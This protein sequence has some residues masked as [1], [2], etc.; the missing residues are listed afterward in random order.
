VSSGDVAIVKQL[1]VLQSIA[2]CAIS[3]HL[4]PE[5]NNP[6]QDCSEQS[7]S[8]ATAEN[9]ESIKIQKYFIF[10]VV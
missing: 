8:A 7:G 1:Y 6:V 10:S 9:S 4:P 5:L 2:L 3:G